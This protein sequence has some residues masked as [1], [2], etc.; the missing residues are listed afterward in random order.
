MTIRVAV[1]G[2]GAITD[3]YYAPA[4]K[5]LS[6]IGEATATA[7][8]DPDQSRTAAMQSRFPDSIVLQDLSNLNKEICDLAVI[9]SPVAFHAEQCIEVLRKGLPVLCE[10]PL[11]VTSSEARSMI[12]AAD[13]ANQVLAVGHYRRFLPSAAAVKELL[14]SE[15]F[16]PIQSFHCREGVR[17][18]WPA[19]SSSFFKKSQGGG[20][21]LLDL[22]VHVL[23]LLYWWFGIPS[24]TSY[25]DDSMGGMESNCTV[26]L[27]YGA[28]FSG[29]VRL[30][31]DWDLRSLYTFVFEKASVE[32][33]P[34]NA[35][36][37]TIKLNGMEHDMKASILGNA[38][39]NNGGGKTHQQGFLSHLRAVIKKVRGESSDY[40]D[41]RDA[42]ANLTIIEQC[43]AERTLM[44]MPWMSPRELANAAS[45]HSQKVTI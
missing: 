31:R 36:T 30:S 15:C 38:K 40:I 43:Y 14:D 12:A 8:Y 2:C 29:E 33:A 22:G 25:A 21:V 5:E 3:L 24:S 16:G 42:L 6:A 34:A 19:Q 44:K 23:D 1:V 26:R 4:L 7:F 13:S 20:G 39:R 17:F 37:I 10:K 18:N 32:W 28:G 35:D 11:A 41:A 9:A 27:D 45:K